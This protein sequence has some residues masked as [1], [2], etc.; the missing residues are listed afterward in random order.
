[1]SSLEDV[2]NKFIFPIIVWQLNDQKELICLFANKVK[3][4]SRGAKLSTYS[5]KSIRHLSAYKK[6]MR[7]NNIIIKEPKKSII[8]VKIDDKKTLSA[9][10]LTVK[11]PK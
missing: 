11:N 6:I 10:N 2:L 3:D 8:F 7:K 5:K 4:I 1:M 9:K